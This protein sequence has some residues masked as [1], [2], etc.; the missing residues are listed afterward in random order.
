MTETQQENTKMELTVQERIQLGNAL[1]QQGNVCTL[2]ILQ[3]LREQLAFTDKEMKACRMQSYPDG[4]IVWDPELVDKVI[5]VIALSKPA[6]AII[7]AA[8]TKLEDANQLHMNQLTLWEKFI[9]NKPT[10]DKTDG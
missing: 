2:L 3:E 8:L 10:G 4:R 1:P 5:L 6:H 7:V 9:T